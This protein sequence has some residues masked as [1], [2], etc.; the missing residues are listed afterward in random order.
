MGLLFMMLTTLMQQ[1]AQQCA[2][3]IHVTGGVLNLLK[4]FWYG[5]QWY[6]SDTG[7][8]RMR[9]IQDDD[10]TIIDISPGDNPT[11]TQSIKRVEVTKGMRTL[12]ICLAPDGNDHDEFNSTKPRSIHHTVPG[13]LHANKYQPLPSGM[14]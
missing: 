9:K 1:A 13:S 4:C 11:C 5:I 7:I 10:P 8:P 6:Y 2:W 3:L 14:V 12:G